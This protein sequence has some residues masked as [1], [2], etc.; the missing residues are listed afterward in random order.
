MAALD[1]EGIPWEYAIDSTGFTAFSA[2][3]SADIAIVCALRG[4]Q[5]SDWI[6]VQAEAG[7]PTLP[8]CSV[9][10]YMRDDARN[11]LVQELAAMIKAAYSQPSPTDGKGPA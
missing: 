6:D 2:F 5:Q 10:L 3:I 7:L 1:A 11:T 4:S 9:F 8:K